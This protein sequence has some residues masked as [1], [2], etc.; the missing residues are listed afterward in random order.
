MSR[1]LGWA[2]L[3]IP[4]AHGGAGAGDRRAYAVLFEETGQVARPCSPLLLTG[5]PGGAAILE[6]GDESQRA[7]FL[8]GNC[9]GRSDGDAMP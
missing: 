8:P 5:V 2:A 7:S 4:E 3:A 6:C 9:D 1:E